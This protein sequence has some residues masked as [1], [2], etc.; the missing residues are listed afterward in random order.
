MPAE[1]ISLRLNPVVDQRFDGLPKGVVHQ[2]Q[3]RQKLIS[4]LVRQV[5]NSPKKH[6]LMQ[7]LF[8]EGSIFTPISYQPKKVTKEQGNVEA[9]EPTATET[10]LLDT[11][12]DIA[13]VFLFMSTQIPSSKNRY[14]VT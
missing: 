13:D 7:E 9:V 10:S 14:S 1:R 2:D 12:L 11:S 6:E 3:A 4:H 8:P 5:L